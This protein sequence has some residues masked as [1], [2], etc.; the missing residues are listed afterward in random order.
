[1]VRTTR[2]VMVRTRSSARLRSSEE[3]VLTKAP[4]VLVTSHQITPEGP[5]QAEDATHHTLIQSCDSEEA[6][7]SVSS[8]KKCFTP[9]CPVVQIEGDSS[10]ST[11]SRGTRRH[12]ARTKTVASSSTPSIYQRVTRSRSRTQE[13]NKMESSGENSSLPEKLEDCHRSTRS[14]KKLFD[15]I[16]ELAEELTDSSLCATQ[17]GG[18]PCSSRTGSGYSSCGPPST[19]SSIRS[20]TVVYKEDA[21]EPLKE[22]EARN[23][24]STDCTLSQMSEG[25]VIDVTLSDPD[26]K[27]KENLTSEDYSH[28]TSAAS[29]DPACLKEAPNE[30]AILREDQQVEPPAEYEG[31]DTSKMKREEVHCSSAPSQPSQSVSTTIHE[32]PSEM[33]VD[34]DEKL[35][36]VDVTDVEAH[37]S[38]SIRPLHEAADV[39]IK[40][41]VAI[42]TFTGDS[43]K[44]VEDDAAE[45]LAK[46][47]KTI[48]LLDSSDE[49]EE[50]DEEDKEQLEVSE[51]E[52]AKSTKISAACIDGLFVIDTRPGNDVDDQYYKEGREGEEAGASKEVAEEEF[53]DEEEEDEDEKA[54]TLFS[55]RDSDVKHLSSSIDPG[56][57]VKDFGGLR[58]T[59][60]GGS[61]KSSHTSQKQKEKKIYDDVMKKSVIGPDFE[62]TDA[63]SPYRESKKALRLKRKE[64]REKTTGEA[65]FNMKSP[66][67][68]Q[69]LKGDLQVLKMRGALDPKRF[70]KKNDM[71]RFPK[72][73]QLATVEDDAI[74][75]HSRVPKKY[76]KSTMV[77]ELL[78]DADFRQSNK[79]K[80][81]HILSERA[82]SCRKKKNR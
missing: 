77:E 49:D 14:R 72:F 45:S 60:D 3:T 82:V 16:D 4:A 51:A 26:K 67:L 63:V 35:Q 69:E 8:N 50:S 71:D 5:A 62:K 74:H 47:R 12:N 17:G 6:P 38:Q 27:C 23:C 24:S 79:K 68:T 75:H 73:V 25:E 10:S 22:D 2:A 44:V 28:L 33:T 48:S 37:T 53:V 9:A 19:S 78:A 54:L 59:F 15:P 58:I 11:V 36:D 13:K 52:R 32:K 20:I 21:V 18:T 81:Q 70:Y 55:R 31:N 57:K 80:Y 30:L 1:M 56:I 34:M 65:W 61:S 41:S 43:Q 46:K 7:S 39:Q 42:T 76:R 64:E 66:E 29:D 40:P